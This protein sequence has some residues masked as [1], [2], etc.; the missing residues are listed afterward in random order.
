MLKGPKDFINRNWRASNG[1]ESGQWSGREPM[2][3]ADLVS[4]PLFVSSD[5]WSAA[6]TPA[7]VP[8]FD[9]FRSPTGSAF[10]LAFRIII[11]R[12]VSPELD[13]IMNILR[14]LNFRRL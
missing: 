12:T 10:L 9:D 4:L 7:A 1:H 14:K 2:V 6:N 11:R 3:N 13:T 5:R 8:L